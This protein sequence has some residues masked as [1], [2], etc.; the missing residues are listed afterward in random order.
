MGSSQDGHYL[1]PYLLFFFK[2]TDEISHLG[3]F[4]WWGNKDPQLRRNAGISEG[5]LVDHVNDVAAYAMAYERSHVLSWRTTSLSILERVT[6]ICQE[7]KSNASWYLETMEE[8]VNLALYARVVVGGIAVKIAKFRD[9]P[10]Q[11]GASKGR[12]HVSFD[13]CCSLEGY[14]AL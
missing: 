5:K 12:G 7:A 3:D 11:S 10:L 4:C 9:V 13:K 8:C 1:V 6:F 14:Q 2:G